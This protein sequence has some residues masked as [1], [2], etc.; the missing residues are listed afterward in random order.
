MNGTLASSYIHLFPSLLSVSKS[1]RL[2]LPS[3]SHIHP[4]PVPS[5]GPTLSYLFPEWCQGLPAWSP[6]PTHSLLSSC[7]AHEALL[8]LAPA[9]PCSSPPTFPSLTLPG[10]SAFS[11]VFNHPCP[12]SGSKLFPS[13]L[14]ETPSPRS[15]QGWLLPILEAQLQGL[16]LREALPDPIS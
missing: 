5:A 2:F 15:S 7:H 6:G 14:P 4:I 9:F 1:S 13:P 10:H 12:R 8:H 11:L 3:P 16:L